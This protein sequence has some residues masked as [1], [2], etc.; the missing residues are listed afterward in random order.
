MMR[1]MKV[2]V[3]GVGYVGSLHAEKYGK[4]EGC[5][6]VGVVDIVRERADAVAQGCD[7][8][9]FYRYQDLFGQVDAVSVAVPTVLHY[10]IARDFLERGVDVL[11]EKPMAA[12]LEE[13]RALVRLAEGRRSIL[14]VGHLERFNAAVAAL[15]GTLNT[16]VFIESHRLS[17]FPGRGTDVDVVLDLMIHDIDIILSIVKAPVEAISAVGVP[18]LSGN[19]DIANARITFANGCVA[20]VTASRV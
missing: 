12:T 13:G 1:T 20:N 10:A 9:P 2:G 15:E 7:T 19:V 3:V 5:R 14:Q 4:L 18:V 11:L 6:L 16:P 17:P 8:R